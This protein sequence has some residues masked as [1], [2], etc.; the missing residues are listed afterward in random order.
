MSTS[1]ELAAIAKKVE[2]K[3]ATSEDCAHDIATDHTDIKAAI[4]AIDRY[5]STRRVNTLYPEF[6]SDAEEEAE[7]DKA[8]AELDKALH[9]Y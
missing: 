5:M 7:L 9:A 8:A 1:T 2:A 4:V 3:K 6:V